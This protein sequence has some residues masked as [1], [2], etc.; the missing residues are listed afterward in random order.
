MNFFGVIIYL[1]IFTNSYYLYE[2]FWI[3]GIE[4]N[5][6][7]IFKLCLLNTIVFS[8]L[9]EWNIGYI[10]NHVVRVCEEWKS[11]IKMLLKY[12][13][14][15][16]TVSYNSIT[17]WPHSTWCNTERN[18]KNKI[19]FQD[20]GKPTMVVLRPA[21]VTQAG[22]AGATQAGMIGATHASLQG[23]LRPSWQR[24]LRPA[25]QGQLARH[26]HSAHSAL[27]LT[28]GTVQSL[29]RAN[30][31]K[32]NKK[33]LFIVEYINVNTKSVPLGQ[34]YHYVHCVRDP[35]GYRII[36]PC[37][38]NVWHRRSSRAHYYHTTKNIYY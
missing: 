2:Y 33:N 12:Y 19:D 36:L 23:R 17:E 37:H 4:N 22:M 3:H 29:C 31:K 27:C 7:H 35:V 26:C 16:D 30:I 6:K 9:F 24:R 15:I 18:S 11:F 25:W 38:F 13:L 8:L 32:N 20:P 10:K 5:P 21:N 14:Q 34:I 28:A 1:S